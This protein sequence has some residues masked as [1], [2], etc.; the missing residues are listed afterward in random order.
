MVLYSPTRGFCQT[1]SVNNFQLTIHIPIPRVDKRIR[2]APKYCS[3]D[4][5]TVGSAV[6]YYNIKPM[7][8]SY[9]EDRQMM[10]AAIDGVTP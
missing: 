5:L 6:L 7:V 4:N 2:M 9:I 1:T 10:T 8:Q 3:L